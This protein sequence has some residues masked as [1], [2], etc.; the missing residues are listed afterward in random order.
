MADL[1][2]L[3]N[4][5][6]SLGPLQLPAIFLGSR[7]SGITG[8]RA[9]HTASAVALSGVDLDVLVVER[10]QAVRSFGNACPY[11]RP[12]LLACSGCSV[13]PMDGAATPQRT[14]VLV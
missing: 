4:P 6:L 13:S 8:D 1:L 9:G 2:C 7:Y 10:V 12:L 3:G 11:Y 14:R 5:V